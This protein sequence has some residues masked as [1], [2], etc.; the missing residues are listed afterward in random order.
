MKTI[1]T[2]PFAPADLLTFR[3]RTLRPVHSKS[4]RRIAR[5][6]PSTSHYNNHNCNT[7][8]LTIWYCNYRNFL[9]D[10]EKQHNGVSMRH[11]LGDSMKI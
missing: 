11:R 5:A 2:R 1:H 9:L 10:V 3:A 4:V 6:F 7:I 8:I